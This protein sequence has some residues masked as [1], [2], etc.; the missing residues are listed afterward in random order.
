MSR[1]IEL[2]VA[3]FAC[4]VIVVADVVF[5]IDSFAV[6]VVHDIMHVLPVHTLK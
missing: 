5:V 3:C 4:V 1:R 6:R 2:V